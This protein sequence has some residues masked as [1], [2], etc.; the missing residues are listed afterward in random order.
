M[1]EL[2]TSNIYPESDLLE[3]GLLYDALGFQVPVNHP[4]WLDDI[5]AIS[6]LDVAGLQEKV[7]ELGRKSEYDKLSV[8]ISSVYIQEL[9]K[10]GFSI[11][12]AYLVGSAGNGTVDLGLAKYQGK[13]EAIQNN[14][15]EV[16]QL[17]L[18][19]RNAPYLGWRQSDVDLEVL[20]EKGSFSDR[21]VANK[22]LI[23]TFDSLNLSKFP[24]YA[25]I[26]DFDEFMNY[27]RYPGAEGANYMYMRTLLTPVLP[28]RGNSRLLNIRR[29]VGNSIAEE[30]QNNH[31][32]LKD[33][34]SVRLARGYVEWKRQEKYASELDVTQEKFVNLDDSQEDL[35]FYATNRIHQS[36]MP[37]KPIYIDGKSYV[38]YF[39]NFS[40]EYIFDNNVDPNV[41]PPPLYP[42]SPNLHLGQMLSVVGSDILSKNTS[43]KGFLPKFI[44]Y[45]PF[46]N[47]LYPHPTNNLNELQKNI[48][49]E[50]N[51]NK[52]SQIKELNKL[53]VE[54]QSVGNNEDNRNATLVQEIYNY[55]FLGGFVDVEEDKIYLN[56]SRMARLINMPSLEQRLHVFPER[57]KE[58]VLSTIKEVAS[59]D[60]RTVLNG[61]GTFSVNIPGL[62]NQTF[63][64]LF[65]HLCLSCSFDGKY[66]APKNIV[67]G[68]NTYPQ[69]LVDNILLAET[70]GYGG[71]YNAY[72]Y[73]LVS[74]SKDKKIDRKN[75]NSFSISDIEKIIRNEYIIRKPKDELWLNKHMPSI[76]RYFLINQIKSS[77]DKTRVDFNVANKGFGL[78]K[79]A[80]W[81]HKIF[82]NGDS[83]SVSNHEFDIDMSALLSQG[84]FRACLLKCQNEVYS[85]AKNVQSHNIVV[86][87]PARFHSV[88]RIL[89]TFLPTI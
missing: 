19:S 66:S 70:L 40:K 78:I 69:W 11:H 23:E 34:P 10:S 87:D 52:D 83:S 3:K 74:D 4:I 49:L 62:Q 9:E 89:K 57:K 15:F 17:K 14:Q 41:C 61:G 30:I 54:I 20:L 58:G 46:W 43:S 47:R 81:L 80:E 51:K 73:N 79:K 31:S 86:G 12:C 77:T 33:H 63:Y 72:L 88:Y 32:K 53:G 50:S 5:A 48:A 85:I 29:T 16:D 36:S 56:L 39:R 82:G 38:S 75:N 25:V 21:L 59:T 28:L 13:V 65:I 1:I 37:S 64:P 55:L 42:F 22:C 8:L 71:E 44:P 18:T 60:I 27:C 2:Q 84:E 45:G 26:N 24:L 68:V 67:C 76:F 6:T 35:T 7:R